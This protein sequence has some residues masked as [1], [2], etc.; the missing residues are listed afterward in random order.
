[1]AKDVPDYVK[2]AGPAAIGARLRR[3]SNEVDGDARRLYAEFGIAFEQRWLGLIDLLSR[4]GALTVGELAGA[5]GI[6]HP[7]VSQSRQ[8][9]ARAG[10]IAWETDGKDQR[11]RK[12]RLTGEGAA[13]VARLA[14]LWQ[15][16]DEAAI[17]IDREAGSA[18]AALE[19]LE[20][21]LRTKPIYDRVRERLQARTML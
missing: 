15:A 12:L 13:L 17:E 5:L 6:S 4:H 7:S 2:E 11:R 19:R 1:M 20:A 3:L 14:P 8:S 9:L 16:L 21:V 18:V 10:L